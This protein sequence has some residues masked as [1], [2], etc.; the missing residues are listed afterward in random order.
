MSTSHPY[1]SGPKNIALMLNQMRKNFPAKV[2]SDTVKRLGIASNNE[3]YVINA[4]TF[5]GLLDE[6]GNKTEAAGAVFS[7]SSDEKFHAEFADL[8]KQAYSELFELHGDEAW[9]L[10]DSELLDFFRQADQTSETIG[11]RQVGT[12]K[13]VSAFAGK[14]ELPSLEKRRTPKAATSSRTKSPLKGEKKPATKKTP[15]SAN[16]APGNGTSR[17]VA[18]NVRIEV[19]LPAD[20]TAETYDN[21]F[22]SIRRNL[23]DG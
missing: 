7:I 5:L 18:V 19:N 12:F 23:M 2:T 13:I 9:A 15:V 16:A 4:L 3:S 8:V 10:E 17:D 1:I 22:A 14:G 6:E 20:A 11:K 21:I